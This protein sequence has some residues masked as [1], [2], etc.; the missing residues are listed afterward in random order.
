MGAKHHLRKTNIPGLDT[1]YL[2]VDEDLCHY[3]IAPE[4]FGPFNALIGREIVQNRPVTLPG[5]RFEFGDCATWQVTK[6][7]SASTN[8]R[9]YNPWSKTP[10]LYE[11][12]GVFLCRR[13]SGAS[14]LGEEAILKVFMQLPPLNQDT[15]EVEYD[16]VPDPDDLD[17][18]SQS[19]FWA[20]GDALIA[21][22][23][24]GCPVTPA[25]YFWYHDRCRDDEPV[26]GGYFKII[27]MEKLPGTNLRHF[28]ELP[29]EQREEVRLAFRAAYP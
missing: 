21:L 8:C 10:G 11:A 24:G 26:P 5:E 29:L 19:A 28:W 22:T 3:R 15:A 20:E 16:F 17:F 1:D 18:D 13:I 27:L 7:L 4:G 14:R 23:E 2:A 25:L 9:S 12:K 6:Q